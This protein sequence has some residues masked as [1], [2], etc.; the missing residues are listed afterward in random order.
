MKPIRAE[1]KCNPE[2]NRHLGSRCMSQT[3]A[4]FSALLSTNMWLY[5]NSKHLLNK[6]YGSWPWFVLDLHPSLSVL[7]WLSLLCALRHLKGNIWKESNYFWGLKVH[8]A[9][10]NDFICRMFADR[11]IKS[12]QMSWTTIGGDNQ[13]RHHLH[14]IQYIKISAGSFGCQ[15]YCMQWI[16]LIWNMFV[17]VISKDDKIR[18][19]VQLWFMEDIGHQSILWP[20]VNICISITL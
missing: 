4:L 18:K 1:V 9:I 16:Q 5:Q 7:A 3:W 14:L 12:C 6:S 19:Y 2:R 10:L 20:P 13:V 11:S 8:I 17:F 15:D